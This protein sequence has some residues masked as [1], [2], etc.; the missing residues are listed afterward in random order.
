MNAPLSPATLEPVEFDPFA[1]AL[2]ERVIPTSEAQREVWLADKLSREASLAF[3]ESISLRLRGAL[4]VAAL[5]GALS[6]LLARH[7]ALR[8]TVS[9]DGT[10]LLVSAAAPCTLERVDL[11]GLTDEQRQHA[12]R[13]ATHLAVETPFDLEQGPLL[14]ATLYRLAERE[15][16]LLMTGHHI[17]CDGW[18]WGLITD[19]L[20]ALY[21]EQTGAAPGP[22][23]ASSYASY[24]AWENAQIGTPE[25]EGH[26]R[27]WLER[28]A[29]ASLPVLELAPDRPRAPVRSFNSR[30]VDWMLDAELVAALRGVGAKAGAS[31]F[32]TLFSGF[33]ATLHRLTGQDD[34]VIGV[35]AAGQSASGMTDLVGHCVNLLPVRVV[36]DGKQ[37]F[38]DF[39]RQSGTA[40][41]DAFDHQTLTYGSL[42]KKLPV[43]RDPSRLPLVSVMFN[44]DQAIKSTSNAYPG[45]EVSFSSNPRHF[46]NFELFVNAA[47]HDGGLC[48]ECQYN[49][50]L[51][52]A[53]TIERWMRAYEALLRSVIADPAQ[54]IA[55]LDWITPTERT[56]L[57]ALQPRAVTLDAQAL[58][59]SAIVRQCALTPQRTALRHGDASLSYAE[60]EQRSNRLSR[61]LRE[62]GVG[63]GDRVGLCLSRG[64]DMV[65]SLLAV[66]KAGATYVPLDPGFPQARLAYYAEDAQL[67]LLLTESTITTAPQAWRSDA[68]QR[69]IRLDQDRAWLDA[70]DTPLAPSAR[71]ADP[72]SAAYIIYTSGST[73]K[74]KGVCLPHRAVA[75]FLASMRVEPGIGVDDRLAAVTTLSFDIAVLEL[76]LPLCA[77]AQ[78]IIVPRETAMDGNLL[79]GLLESSG[80]SLMQATPGMWRMLLDTPWRGAPNFKALVGGEA[81]PPDLAFDLL[82]RCGELWNMYGPTE[83]TVWSTLWRVDREAVAK[84]GVSI[85]RPIANTSVWILNEVL[86]PCPIGVP[87]EICIGGEG[88]ALGYLDRPELTAD[89]F[90]ADR[91]DRRAGARLYR[92]GD[93]GRWRNDGLLEHL[94]RLDFQVKVRGYRIEL[95]EI[96]AACNDL[97]G[98]GQSVVLARED[99]P[100]DVRLVAYLTTN[101]G[102][103]VDEAGLRAHLRGRLPE[104]MLPQHL[105][106]L[107]A[108]PLLPNGKVDRK[109]LPAPDL[110]H[111]PSAE[112]VAPRTEL[113]R[114][115]AA[116]MQ[117][118]LKLPDIGIHDD[119]FSL[120]GHSLLAARLVGMLNR[121]LGVQLS[122]RTLFEA[123]TV[124][125]LAAAVAH[126]QGQGAG[127]QR[128]PI[129]KRAQQDQAPLTLMQERIRFI[130]EM[131]PGRLDYNTP[132]GHRLRGPINLE[133]FE[134]AFNRMVER[135]PSLRTR[136]VSTPAGPVQ[137]ID[138]TL[139]VSLLPLEDLTHLPPDERE[140]TL[141]RRMEEMIGE[142]FV[143]D[144]GPLF[145]VR[146]FKL[147][148]E[149]HALFFMTHHIIW[150][151]WSFDLLYTEMTALYEA[152]LRDAP[153][154]LAPLPVSYGDFA[155]WHNEWL[156][157]DEVRQQ[158]QYWTDQYRRGD[159][160]RAP[161]SDLLRRPQVESTG[162]TAWL[163]VDPVQAE[164]VRDLAKKTGTTLSIVA[165]SAFAAQMAQWLGQ[166]NPTIG[167]PVRGRP[168]AELEGV[169]GFFNNM[170]PMRMPVDMAMTGLEWIKSVRQMLVQAY[171]NQDVPFELVAQELDTQR[172]SGPAHL[173]HVMYTF[174]DVRQRPTAW[175]PLAHERIKIDVKGATEDINLWLV[176]APSGLSGGVRYDAT[177]YL[178]ETGAAL[179]DRFLLILDRLVQ[180]PSAPMSALLAP[181]AAELAAV[182]DWVSPAPRAGSPLS[183]LAAQLANHPQRIAL[184]HG[185]RALTFGE[186]GRR[187]ADIGDQLRAQPPGAGSTIAISVDDPIDELLITVATLLQQRRC[188]VLDPGLDT[189]SLRAALEA[190]ASPLL[191][192]PATRRGTSPHWLDSERLGVA[193]MPPRAPASS[194]AASSPRAID[195]AL[196][197]DVL[198][199]LLSAFQFEAG[200]VI[201]TLRD[202]HAGLPVVDGMLALCAGAT[203][204]L[205]D[206]RNDLV[207]HCQAHPELALLRASPAAWNGLLASQTAAL[208]RAALIDVR[209]LGETVRNALQRRGVRVFGALHADALGAAVAG[210]WQDAS[211][212]AGVFGRPLINAPSGI[213]MQVIDRTGQ[214]CPPGV[215]GQLDYDGALAA[216]T[217]CRW[218]SDGRLQFVGPVEVADTVMEE[219]APARDAVGATAAIDAPSPTETALV[220]VW[221]TL[222]G[223]QSISRADN[224][225]ELGGTSL[226][227]MQ[228]VAMLEKR[229]GRS[230][231]P[232]RYVFDSLGQLAAAYDQ[233]PQAVPAVASEPPPEAAPARGLMK[234]LAGL[235]GRG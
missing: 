52:D 27:F 139:Q 128:A 39:V 186:A 144:R 51:F 83:T 5:T 73:G 60:L 220:E 217:H 160:P 3:N 228:A 14:R 44:V 149:D 31:A 206:D 140:T 221:Q 119:F 130:E 115:V 171:A 25:L 187:I 76:L 10:E 42:L 127:P 114:S 87:G 190:N 158:L 108:I 192:C 145:K 36:I 9:P 17:V 110:S 141:I 172:R 105:V 117:G 113:E 170:L 136:I 116:A 230:I 137:Q 151:G 229:L 179:R 143:L 235:V 138:P 142:V 106:V 152:C 218:R 232:R 98:V 202:A 209:H 19:D 28:F 2:V 215:A 161:V 109:A 122:L 67:S 234:R 34:L 227:A 50:D 204:H 184:V 7:D 225:F 16:L 203:W 99:N 79:R 100:G 157:S 120:G 102:A 183:A 92:T 57:E 30:R 18:S 182:R 147:G 101:G 148:A 189:A 124:E 165:M 22:D 205:L 224:F 177:A 219:S 155:A 213:R 1:G 226:Q 29:G 199:G 54:P 84:R 162:E 24:V 214:A 61:T 196:L 82:D 32:A 41:L 134:R 71:D 197:D 193:A 164:R 208:P 126:Q 153:A 86:E 62:R 48:L 56:A 146:L 37:A 223:E 35:P 78:V 176:D 185:P 91:F 40:L 26:E 131:Y 178:P 174:Q 64:F 20:G 166:D 6:A 212:P 222:L 85:G 133:A 211:D 8:S 55:R 150:D 107:A 125:K 70:P 201:V 75:N 159:P 21:A 200:A 72:E 231:S 104:Y 11:A 121:D 198:A 156:K 53:A 66:L 45:L 4:D 181:S 13:E 94:G 163:A 118:V 58:M 88:V 167:L 168:S 47:Q 93:R 80:A 15:H 132:S 38:A 59:H 33:A 46:E 173:Y 112:R 95:G 188:L 123:P 65:V 96:E 97:A 210:G 191:V 23:P 175:G 74:P 69:V 89:R 216:Q 207:R 90:V 169:M 129:R 12:L 233:A 135:Q 81:L 194:L 68:A 49:T 103:K 77:G 43:R 195:A 180:D 154:D 63:R 111:A